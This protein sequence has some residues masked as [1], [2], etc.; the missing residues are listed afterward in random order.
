M[1]LRLP[2]E[3]Q[4][5][6]KA[7]EEPQ[8]IFEWFL[9]QTNRDRLALGASSP[10]FCSCRDGPQLTK[11]L[12]CYF[13]ESLIRCLQFHPTSWAEGSSAGSIELPRSGRFDMGGPRA[14]DDKRS[15]LWPVPSII[16]RLSTS[17]PP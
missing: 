17:Y 2:R 9:E 4:R 5:W 13:A 16:D 7:R 8:M 1:R 14:T 10:V 11:C 12:E 6:V 15:E 3:T